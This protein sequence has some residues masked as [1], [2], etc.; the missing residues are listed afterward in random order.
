MLGSQGLCTLIP[1]PETSSVDAPRAEGFQLA[2]VHLGTKF[3]LNNSLGK[4]I[5]Y[6]FLS[7]AFLCLHC[8]AKR[9]PEAGRLLER[10]TSYLCFAEKRY[11]KAMRWFHNFLVQTHPAKWGQSHW[12][13]SFVQY[14]YKMLSNQDMTR[15]VEDYF[16]NSGLWTMQECPSVALLIIFCWNIWRLRNFA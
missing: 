10:S 1:A 8:T 12:W 4:L 16:A 13:I 5:L 11:S 2:V 14:E 6:W 15:V 9:C 7:S 3:H